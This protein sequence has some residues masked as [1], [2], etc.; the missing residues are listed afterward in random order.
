MAQFGLERCVRDAEVGSSNLPIP[1]IYRG[2]WPMRYAIF[3]D[4]HSNL[5]AFESVLQAFKEEKVDKYFFVGDIVGYGADPKECIKLLKKLQAVSVC[6]NH[7]WAAVGKT[8]ISYFNEYAKAAVLWTRDA[9][10]EEEREFLKSLELVYQDADLTLVHGTLDAPGDFNY[11]FDT[12]T[13]LQTI[14]LLKTQVGFVGHSHTPFIIKSEQGFPVIVGENKAKI[15]KDKKYLVNVGS[16]GQPRDGDPRAAYCVYDKKENT[17]EIKRVIY[18]IKSA[19]NKIL[20]AGLP[21]ILAD[22]LA[23]GR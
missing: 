15:E 11:I 13:A 5:E 23:E 1:T 2:K 8:S 20:K 10:N 14:G 3:S 18:D 21:E 17:I 9:L 22:R 4:V 16:V 12:Y 6:G 7:D 19:Q